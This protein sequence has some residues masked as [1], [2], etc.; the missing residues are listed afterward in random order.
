VIALPTGASG[1]DTSVTVGGTSGNLYT[2]YVRAE[3][4]NTKTLTD[5]SIFLD[6]QPHRQVIDEFQT[7][8]RRICGNRT[9]KRSQFRRYFPDIFPVR[10]L[11]ALICH[12]FA[13]DA[14][15][16]DHVMHH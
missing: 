3:T 6:A 16:I 5:I 2:L 4:F 10:V 12:A 15:L 13:G 7:G 9:A 1:T 14:L 8:D 11:E